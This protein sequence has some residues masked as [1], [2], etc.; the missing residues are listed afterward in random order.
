VVKWLNIDI[1]KKKNQPKRFK[2]NFIR[3]TPINSIKNTTPSKRTCLL[4]FFFFK[5]TELNHLL[6]LRT[7]LRWANSLFSNATFSVR[8]PHLLSFSSLEYYPFSLTVIIVACYEYV[9]RT[10]TSIESH[11][12][13]LFLV[14]N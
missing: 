2:R 9:N 10:W 12:F 14:G 13:I 6:R 8:T 4:V 7:L 1:L 11:L 5:P 3:Q